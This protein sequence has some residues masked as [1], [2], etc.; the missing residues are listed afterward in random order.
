VHQTGPKDW[1]ARIQAASL[2]GVPILA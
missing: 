2:G 1:Q